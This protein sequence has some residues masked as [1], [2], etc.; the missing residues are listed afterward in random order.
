[1][2]NRQEENIDDF[3]KN[4]LDGFTPTP[5]DRNWN[6]IAS[7]LEGE[8]FDAHTKEYFEQIE[9]TPNPEIWNNIKQK[10]PLS[11]LVRNQ[12]NRLSRIAAVLIIFMIVLLVFNKKD[13]SQS[14]D[15][16]AETITEENPNELLDSDT[17]IDFVFAINDT[18]DAQQSSASDELSLED[19]KT[20]EDFWSSIMD[21]DD[22]F[23]SNI[24]EEVISKS[25]EPLMQ[26]PIENLEA[27]LPKRKNNIVVESTKP[28][29]SLE[30]ATL[31]NGKKLSE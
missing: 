9:V 28:T 25:L 11:L 7:E 29:I 4:E 22:D 10:L 12:L 30:S 2:K 8:E 13:N 19:E 5:P 1:M 17:P 18:E 15:A 27:A 16:I 3:F 6:K 20:I 23:I 14:T 31:S 26:L 24:D 21:D